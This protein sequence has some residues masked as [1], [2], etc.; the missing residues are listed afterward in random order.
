MY[1]EKI[2]AIEGLIKKLFLLFCNLKLYISFWG[3]FCK[4]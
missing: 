1:K 3:S 4:V 2:I